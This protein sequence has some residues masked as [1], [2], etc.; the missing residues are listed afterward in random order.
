MVRQLLIAQRIIA[1]LLMTIFGSAALAS[2]K[3]VLNDWFALG[4]GCRARSDL[5]GNVEMK[6]QSGRAD[7]TSVHAARFFFKDFKLAD[8]NTSTGLR[9][10]GREC[11]VRLN[12]NPPPGKKI[13]ALHAQTKFAIKKGPGYALD[14]LS[15]LKLGPVSLGHDR[16]NFLVSEVQDYR[17][18][19]VSLSAGK[20]ALTGLPQLGCGEPKIIG[21]DYSWIVSERQ[22][23]KQT[24]PVEL[25]DDSSLLIEAVLG[26]CG[27]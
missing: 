21:F 19:S 10:F 8:S 22:P 15:E 2:D 13:L 5:A 12:I 4:S 14:L 18:H 26:D 1:T 27:A 11:A 16:Q 9:Q 23:G 24:L 7:A 6:L 3:A 25:L 20:G 17:S